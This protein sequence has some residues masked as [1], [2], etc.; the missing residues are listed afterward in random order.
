MPLVAGF[1]SALSN[2]RGFPQS[3][4]PQRTYP[5]ISRLSEIDN[6]SAINMENSDG[7]DLDS[8]SNILVRFVPLCNH[9][10][11]KRV[12]FFDENY[13]VVPYSESVGIMS[14][15]VFCEL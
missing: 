7:R 13:P 6:L 4:T 15:Q 11:H 10:Y 5:F 2:L 12:A 8:R 1:G 3:D 14:G 9:D